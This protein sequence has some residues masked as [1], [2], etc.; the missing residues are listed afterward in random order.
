MTNPSFLNNASQWL[1]V[2][3]EIIAWIN[4]VECFDITFTAETETFAL[5]LNNVATATTLLMGESSSVAEAVA[6]AASFVIDD[7]HGGQELLSCEH[8]VSIGL[9]CA[10]CL[11]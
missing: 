4:D 6:H 2:G 5:R 11:T 9:P 10:D 8:G 7:G 3:R 1:V